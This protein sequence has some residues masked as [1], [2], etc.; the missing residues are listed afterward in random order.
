MS[1][2]IRSCSICGAE[3]EHFLTNGVE[4]VCFDCFES[5]RAARIVSRFLDELECQENDFN[6]VDLIRF[7]RSQSLT[8]EE[9]IC[10]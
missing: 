7:P 1:I 2:S 5:P 8:S 6:E 10:S 4:L 9:V 3:E